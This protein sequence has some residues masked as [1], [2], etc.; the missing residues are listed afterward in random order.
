KIINSNPFKNPSNKID[1]NYEQNEVNTAEVDISK[2]II[3][4]QESQVTG[5]QLKNSI[6]K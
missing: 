3:R 6:L 5:L 2:S 1:E 4:Q